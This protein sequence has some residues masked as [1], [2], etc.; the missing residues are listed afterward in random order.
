[1]IERAA[2]MPGG[3]LDDGRKVIAL[4]IPHGTHDGDLV[5]HAA[6]V[7]QNV[8]DRNARFSATA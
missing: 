8:G 4:V 2:A 5:D 3:R 7:R 6:D 1:M